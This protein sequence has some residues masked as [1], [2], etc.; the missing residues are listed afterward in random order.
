MATNT[1]WDSR[2][3]R[4]DVV[5]PNGGVQLTSNG[6]TWRQAVVELGKYAG[7]DNILLRFDFSTSSDFE[8]G[9]AELGGAYLEAL[10]GNQLNDGLQFTIDGKVYEFDMGYSLNVPNA[11]GLTI[12]DGE[13][14]T[15]TDG[16]GHV[17]V[18]EFDS[19]TA[20]IN[21]NAI[22]ISIN[23]T[24]TAMDVA[25]AMKK[26]IETAVTNGKLS[27]QVTATIST[28][29]V[30]GS[31]TATRALAVMITGAVRLTQTYAP[32]SSF[33]SGTT[34][35]YYAI[36][37]QGNGIG[38]SASG[39]TL[40]PI[41]VNRVLP[42]DP[43][44]RL[45]TAEE[46]AKS[47]QEKVDPTNTYL[48]VDGS[49]IHV[50]HLA[51]TVM[52]PNH[53]TVRI[54]PLAYSEELQGDHP[55]EKAF[56]NNNQDRFHNFMRGQ[57]NAH[58]GFYIDDIIVGFA[59]RGELITGATA[60]TTFNPVPTF[61][62]AKQVPAGYYQME[63]REA[64]PY[65][66]WAN[67]LSP[68]Y[69]NIT[70]TINTNDRLN[71]SIS[72][73]IPSVTDL[74][75]LDTFQISD[76]IT[77][78]TF[79]FVAQYN[80]KDLPGFPAASGNIPIRYT[81]TETA[82]GMATLIANAINK[83]SQISHL[84]DVTAAVSGSRQLIRI[85][86]FGA[87]SVTTMSIYG[88]ALAPEVTGSTGDATSTVTD[89]SQVKAPNSLGF[90]GK[91]ASLGS[92]AA[93][94]GVDYLNFENWGG[95]WTDADKDIMPGDGDDLMCWAAAASNVL[96][97]TG[98]GL[99]AGMDSSDEMFQ[100]FQDHWTDKGGLSYIGWDWWFDGTNS[101]PT[102]GG[103]SQVDVPGGGFYA[104]LVPSDYI[105]TRGQGSE[106]EAKAMSDIDQYSRAGY[107]VALGLFGTIAHAITC[108]GFN[109]DDTLS[110]TNPNYYK[111]IY[112]TDSDDYGPSDS[113]DYYAVTWDAV[114]E[115]YDFDSYYVGAYIGEVDGLEE[116]SVVSVTVFD[117]LGD[118]NLQRDQGQVII[119]CNQIMYSKDYG[120]VV[121]PDNRDTNSNFA[122]PG[123][124][125]PPCCRATQP[126]WCPE[127]RS[128]TT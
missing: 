92:S 30:N 34:T 36:T 37:R 59:E 84:F 120:I 28:Q 74:H 16:S 49:L 3:L 51:V 116:R 6:G 44:C 118:E 58:E 35:R 94:T 29:Q 75:H 66:T 119:D 107:G 62:P 111:G 97:W 112:I 104:G 69:A 68:Y 125:A 108:W 73:T 17:Q 65:G 96:Q 122:H 11:A 18:F 95:T 71:Q 20:R 53:P 89:L 91:I 61:D 100:Y 123:S 22:A 93:G 126:A 110:P 64:T 63:I 90:D 23:S 5:Q 127:F 98:W 19:N 48:K 117:G 13:Q 40:V 15:I 106:A 8:I 12:P 1:D 10:A 21:P 2:P 56:P 27:P 103:W 50:Y 32:L 78:V 87:A 45:M 77:T 121:A 26:A 67:G 81:G 43:P 57:N 83:A 33:P 38:N 101:G 76:G 25:D 14:F 109:Y 41:Y 31:G 113:M 9:D 70:N 115:H 7:Q 60:D 42:T 39:A 114:S 55:A 85:D 47:I 46:V 79:R 54:L 80:G 99:V 4:E 128:S 86:L 52:D 82:E 124:P 105:H 88:K 102:G 72:L 24:M